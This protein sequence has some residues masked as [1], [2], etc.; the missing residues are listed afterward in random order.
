MTRPSVSLLDAF[1]PTFCISCKAVGSLFCESCRAEIKLNLHPVERGG[2]LGWSTHN[3]DSYLGNL[4]LA[5]KER[6]KTALSSYLANLAI[7][8]LETF[9]ERP[10]NLV[11]LPT[12]RA[13]FARRGFDANRVL[14][15]AVAKRTGLTLN[16]SVLR[17]S[18]QPGDQRGLSSDQRVQ[19]LS[20][21]MVA[22]KGRGRVLLVDDVVTTG[23]SVL[24]GRRAL[25][26]AG[27]EVAGFI[28]IAETL[29]QKS[30]KN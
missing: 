28:T 15:K 18:R 4:I 1:V 16:D 25:L 30:P 12:S 21:S 10:F 7:P 23:A 22:R 8:A 27:F 2:F 5:F 19:N 26:E 3:L 9:R 20:G 29:L 17:L 11:A 13:A 6:G 14:A 24:E